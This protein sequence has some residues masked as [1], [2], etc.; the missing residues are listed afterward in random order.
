MNIFISADDNYIQAAQ[1][2]LTSFFMNNRIECHNIYFMYCSVREDNLRLLQKLVIK[3]NAIFIPVHIQTSMFEAFMQTDRF[4]VEVYFRLLIPKLVPE[5][6]ERAMWMDVDLVVNGELDEF[7]YQDF[8]GKE[9]VAC[10]DICNRPEKL[11]LLGCS[12][13]AI[14]INSGVLL[15]NISQMKKYCIGNYYKFYQ[16]HEDAIFWPDQDILNGMFE[17]KIKILDCDLYNVQVSN[18][19]FKNQY[20]LE[21][22]A[23][24]HYTG[25]SKPWFK[26]YT[27]AA[28]R[29]WDYY[30]A[31]T[32]NCGRLYLFRRRIHRWMQKWI[33]IPLGGVAGKLY[34]KSGML[35]KLW[36]LLK[37]R[38]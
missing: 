35:Q 33:W 5:K 32:F 18:W 14:Y 12:E 10:R 8:E 29:M 28:A 3:N 21:Q 11:R 37:K 22:A 26:T 38:N 31:K 13:K 16:D 23:I 17:G 4:P 24:I 27:N 1:V 2:M 6:E 19:R 30:Y 36:K 20:D 25:E 7:Y 34:A 15:F 9:F